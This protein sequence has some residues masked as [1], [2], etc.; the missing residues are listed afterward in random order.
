M[1]PVLPARRR[2]E[3][4]AARIDGGTPGPV[5]AERP[6]RHADLVALVQ[7]M[8]AAPAPTPRPDFVADLRSRLLVEADLVLDQVDTRLSLPSTSRT[9]RDRRFAVAAG[10]IALVGAGS[11]I[12][13][14]SQSA[15]PGDALYPIKRALETAQTTLQPDGEARAARML[16]LASDRLAEVAEVAASGSAEGYAALPDALD[17]FSAQAGEAADEVLADYAETGDQ[18]PVVELRDFTAESMDTLARLDAQVPASARA[19]LNN[20]ALVLVTID[21]RARAACPTCGGGIDEVPA[22]FMTAVGPDGQDVVVAPDPVLAPQGGGDGGRGD[23]SEVQPDEV[24][25]DQ[26]PS[27]GGDDGGGGGGADAPEVRDAPIVRDLTDLLTGSGDKDQDSGEKKGKKG[28]G[29]VD[30]V[31]DPVVDPLLDPLTGDDGLLG[32]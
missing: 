27:V 15:L 2:A 11:S 24:L 19:A 31:L 8:R 10:A 7:A 3:E 32:D 29:K 26:Q 14:A 23:G 12:A 30:D 20:A 28:K 17:D 16:D 9:R 13:V 5:D 6:D 18:D 21:E 1:T 22:A 4:F 25:E